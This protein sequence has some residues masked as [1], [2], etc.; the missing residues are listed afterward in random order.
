MAVDD[1]AALQR[2]RRR[3]ARG[4]NRRR[5]VARLSRAGAALGGGE[6]RAHDR[7]DEHDQPAGAARRQGPA[8][9]RAARST[10]QKVRF[11][12]LK[13]WRNYLCLHAARAGARRRATRC[14]RTAC[15]SELDAIAAWAER[16]TRRLARATCRRR[17]APEVWDEVAAEPDLCQRAASARTIEQVLP[18]QGAARGGAGGRH[19]R[20][21]SSAAVRPR[22]AARVAELGRSGGAARVHA[23]RRRRRASPRGRRRRAP[24]RDGHAARA[25]AAVQPARPARARDC[26]ARSSTRLVGADGSAQHREPRPRARAARAGG[27]RGAREERACCSTCST[28]C[29]QE[30]G[31]AGA[32][33]DRRLRARI[34]SGRPGSRRARRHARRDRAARTRACSSCASA[35]RAAT[36]LDEAL[37]PLLN[38]MRAVDAAAAGARATALRRALDPPRRRA[39]GALDRGARPRARRR[40][41]R[42]CR[43]TSRRSCARICSSASTDDDRH[44]RDA[45]ATDGT[46]L[47]L[48]RARASGSTIRTLE[49]HTAIFPSPFD[50]RAAGAARHADRRAG[51]ERRRRRALRRAVTRIALDLAEAAD[52]GMFVLF[53]SHRDVRAMAAE[54]RARGVER[55]WP[56]LVHGEDSARRAARALSRHRA[57]RSCSAPR[58]SGRASTCRATRCAALLIAKLPFRVPDRADHGRALR[59]DR[60]A[61]RRCVRRVH[62]AARVA[63][64]EAGLRPA[65][66]HAAPTA[67]SS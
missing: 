3:A 40:A 2:R 27:A 8:V 51:A 44:E 31:R 41:C 18:L 39:D 56:L 48:P 61:R 50:Y 24:R 11:A 49:P 35:S 26:S 14:S 42:R 32:A 19:R 16:T 34:R 36:K 53:T 28:R 7:L 23:A 37:A 15:A 38:E 60:G 63:A 55:R 6:R 12:L 43:S 13:G 22:R 47:R 58:R 52:G 21:P 65:D 1:R 62:A 59:G 64:A 67:A 4:G 9:P 20:Q 66:P 57:R 17:R 33:P 29:S 10:D 54:L 5:Q 30:S 25:A 45:R 46:R